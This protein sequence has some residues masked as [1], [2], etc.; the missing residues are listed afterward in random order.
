MDIS[1][2]AVT[3][4]GEKRFKQKERES[5]LE[6]GNLESYKMAISSQHYQD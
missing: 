6:K 5:D 3:L 1:I 4:F 2:S